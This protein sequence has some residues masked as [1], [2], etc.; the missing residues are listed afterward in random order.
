MVRNMNNIENIDNIDI[1]RRKAIAD[2]KEKIKRNS[3]YLSPANKERLE[4][5]KKLMFVSGNEFTQWMQK[6]GIMNN[7]TDVDRVF[8]YLDKS[9]HEPLGF[10]KDCSAYFGEFAERIMIQTFD[11]A[12]KMPPCN[13]GFDWTCKRGDKIDNKARCLSHEC[14]RSRWK[15][16]IRQNNIADWFILSAWDDRESLNPLHVWV[17]HKEDIVRGRKFWMIDSF[18]INNTPKGLKELEKYEVTNRLDKLRE[19]CNR[20]NDE[21]K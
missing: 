5:M 21:I 6:N 15:Y 8:R 14:D 19:I 20:N 13:P 10:N 12:K 16:P 7:P 18:S 1:L 2:I 3:K 11:G 17:F 4:D 9:G